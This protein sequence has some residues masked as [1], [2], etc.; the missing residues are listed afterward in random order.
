MPTGI[1]R[2]R[3]NPDGGSFDH[4]NETSSS[5]KGKFSWLAERIFDN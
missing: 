2:L 4:G 5:I 1:I 3:E